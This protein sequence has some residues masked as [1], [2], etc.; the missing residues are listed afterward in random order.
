MLTKTD[1]TEVVAKNT[2]IAKTEAGKVLDAVINGISSELVNGGEVRIP[3]FLTLKTVQK[4][5]RTGHNPRTGEKVQIAACKAVSVKVGK[6]LK[7]AV[8][9]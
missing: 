6:T 5:A 7:D 2:G 1:L 9:G 8:K 4:K 3:G